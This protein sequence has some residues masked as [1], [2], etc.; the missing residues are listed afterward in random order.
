MHDDH[1]SPGRNP[2]KTPTLIALAILGLIVLLPLVID[3][4]GHGSDGQ[5]QNQALQAAE[6]MNDFSDP[7]DHEQA[8]EKSHAVPPL[9]MLGTVPFVILLLCIALLPLIPRTAHWWESNM[10]RLAVAMAAGFATLIYYFF[11][12]SW[13]GAIL[14]VE[15]AIPGEYIPFIVLLFSLYVISGGISI[16]GDLRA[17][18]EVNT[19]FIAT[20]TLIASFIGTTG[21]S[22]LL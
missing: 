3:V 10:N 15:H 21:A 12:D 14:A 18:P 6:G 16:T 17:T 11:A 2:L 7:H 9:W 20:G 1:A 5:L 4:H 8:E 19:A 22:M 13:Q